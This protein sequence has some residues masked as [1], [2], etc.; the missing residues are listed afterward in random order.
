M[1]I[2]NI[3]TYSAGTEVTAFNYRMV[4]ALTRAGFTADV[5]K[6]GDNP[7]Y[8][9]KAGDIPTPLMLSKTY[10]DDY[11]PQSDYI[12]V[13]VCDHAAEA[14]PIIPGVTHRFPLTYIDPKA[15]DDTPNESA[16]YDATVNEIGRE[17]HYLA[18]SISNLLKNA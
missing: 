1:S 18:T 6:E 14:C 16:A 10:D 7:R 8:E 17:M 12:A 9:M 4:A 2:D 15:H 13:M 11:N 3:K 5:V